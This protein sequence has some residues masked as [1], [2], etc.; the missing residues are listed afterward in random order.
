[1]EILKWLESASIVLSSSILNYKTFKNGF[2]IKIE[3]MIKN[4]TILFIKEYS[5]QYARNYSYHWQDLNGN[6]IIRRDNSPFHP[7][8]KNATYR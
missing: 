5:D 4:E 1:M 6:M 3:V 2:Y 8:L 7:Y